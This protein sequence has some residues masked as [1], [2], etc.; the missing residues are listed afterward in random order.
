MYNGFPFKE[1][2]TIGDTY[3]VRYIEG[4][5]FVFIFWLG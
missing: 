4:N 3:I 2:C 5:I 1:D